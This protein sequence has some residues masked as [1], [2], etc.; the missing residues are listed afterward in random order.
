VNRPFSAFGVLMTFL[1]LAVFAV[2]STSRST[3]VQPNKWDNRRTSSNRYVGATNQVMVAA[4]EPND[5]DQCSASV[6]AT[7]RA[8]A[9]DVRSHAERGNEGCGGRETSRLSVVRI[10]V[11]P[12]FLVG[13][14][15]DVWDGRSYYDAEYD[16][17]LYG[18]QRIDTAGR[19]RA[20]ERV[21]AEPGDAGE[22]TAAVFRS[23]FSSQVGR[24][25]RKV[26]GGQEKVGQKIS[27]AEYADFVAGLGGVSDLSAE[28]AG[29]SDAS[30]SVRSGDWLRHSAALSLNRVGKALQAAA[31][32]L[33]ASEGQSAAELAE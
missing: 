15:D 19:L 10:E 14:R 32:V 25:P 21:V 27:W 33:R 18:S 16:H 26:E 30:R 9:P 22:E 23:V 4:M 28:V 12:N 2:S 11:A 29:V 3:T 5:A 1:T 6:P 13:C 17:V 7:R 20:A 8:G 31:V 24:Q